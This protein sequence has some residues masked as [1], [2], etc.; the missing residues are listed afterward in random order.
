MIPRGEQRSPG[1]GLGTGAGAGQPTSDLSGGNS[2]RAGQRHVSYSHGFDCGGS[3]LG[4]ET[5]A[6]NG[7]DR[8][9]RPRLG[10]ETSV[11]NLPTV[12]IPAVIELE[13]RN[14]LWKADEV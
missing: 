6:I 9:C 13:W 4:R 8:W 3:G 10:P 5:L 11:I 12:Q 14:I 7:Q 1:L 2:W